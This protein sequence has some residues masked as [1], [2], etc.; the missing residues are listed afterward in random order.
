MF[1]FLD[2]F[3]K[4]FIQSPA[5]F[6]LTHHTVLLGQVDPLL[7]LPPLDPPVVEVPTTNE[8]K[9]AYHHFLFPFAITLLVP[10]YGV[11]GLPYL[12]TGR[13]QLHLADLRSSPYVYTHQMGP[14]PI[15]EQMN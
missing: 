14:R 12:V 2:C 5:R 4:L 7:L 15:W 10:L 13:L 1:R 6:L 3:V 8:P 11:Y 9:K